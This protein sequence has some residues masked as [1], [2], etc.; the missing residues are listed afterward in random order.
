MGN[1]NKSYNKLLLYSLYLNCTLLKWL[2]YWHYRFITEDITETLLDHCKI[3][4]PR[5]KKWCLMSIDE[6]PEDYHIEDI[7]S[8]E[9]A[10]K[11]TGEY[12]VS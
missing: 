12:T 6:L 7:P 5:A 2:C 1:F 3:T 11:K 4:V 9:S 8:S 10:V